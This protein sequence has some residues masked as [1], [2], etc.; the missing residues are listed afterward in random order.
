MADPP[1]ATPSAHT[2]RGASSGTV[3]GNGLGVNALDKLAPLFVLLVLLG[4]TTLRK[5]L[6]QPRSRRMRGERRVQR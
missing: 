3:A 2:H 4:Y 1:L 5:C 6:G